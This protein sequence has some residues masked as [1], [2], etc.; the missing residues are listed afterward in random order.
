MKVIETGHL[1][2]VEGHGNVAVSIDNGKVKDVQ[3]QIFEGP[4]LIERLTVGKTPEEVV[5]I[6]PRIC[7]ICSASHKM[8]AI[9]A[10][11][12]ALSIKPPGKVLLLRELLH[13]G[14]QIESHAL[15]IYYLALPDY[16]GYPNAIALADKFP[17]EVQIALEMKHFANHILKTISGRFI[18]GENP[19]IGGFGKYPSRE[20]LV[21]IRS[22]ARQ[23]MPF[24]TK[25]VD[26]FNGI[27]YPDTPEADA[28]FACLNPPGGRYGF[29]GDEILVSTG[30]KVSVQDY[31]KLTNEEV[32][33]HSFCKRSRY[34]GKSF[35]VGALA[36]VNLLGERLEGEAKKMYE[37]YYSKKWKTN[38]LYNNAA[39]A[40]EILYAMERVQTIIDEIIELPDEPEVKYTKKE[41]RAAGA[42]EAPRGTL[43]HYYELSGGRITDADIITPTAQNADDIEKFCFEATGRILK[44]G[45]DDAVIDMLNL[46]VRAYDPCISCSA[47]L[48]TLGGDAGG[49]IAAEPGEKT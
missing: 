43:Y 42:V 10:M 16:L 9:K 4:R 7:A 28:V 14:E 20:E 49:R 6:V 2:R 37:K 5:N 18:H 33:P 46:I 39:Q 48:I 31:R 1:A 34:K 29:M 36:R 13:M 19:I 22:R 17:L 11:E 27:K 8:A 30:D 15:H 40:L 41:G 35:T 25:T 45:N 44:D 32:K 12:N 47:H 21:W 26:L 38:P 3:F 24:T 23:F